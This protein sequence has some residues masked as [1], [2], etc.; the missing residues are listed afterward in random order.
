MAW[1]RDG[2]KRGCDSSRCT[3]YVSHHFCQRSLTRKYH[4]DH[5]VMHLHP[6][7]HTI[8]LCLM[9]GSLQRQVITHFLLCEFPERRLHAPSC[10]TN[11]PLFKLCD[12]WDGNHPNFDRL[13]CHLPLKTFFQRQQRRMDRILQADIVVVPSTAKEKNLRIED[14]QVDKVLMT[15]RFSR[16]VFA[17]V[18]FFPI[19]LAFQ[20]QKEP[21]G[22][23]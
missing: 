15:H 9:W 20:A 4:S 3:H 11:L 12:R 5:Y 8:Q 23:T 17:L 14:S 21:D 7:K 16:N 18:I 2:R 13:L 19:A 1:Q 22:S 6:T 10:A